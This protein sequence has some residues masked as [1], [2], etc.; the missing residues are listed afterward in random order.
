MKCLGFC[1]AEHEWIVVADNMDFSW[2]DI[3]PIPRLNLNHVVHVMA[4]SPI[5]TKYL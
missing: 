2:S 5:F 3:I 1:F 4:R